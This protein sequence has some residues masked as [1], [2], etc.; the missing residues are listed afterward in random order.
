M[1]EVSFHSEIQSLRLGNGV[2]QG[3]PP[4]L[5]PVRFGDEQTVQVDVVGRL[6]GGEL[7]GAGGVADQFASVVDH[8]APGPR[9]CREQHGFQAGGEIGGDGFGTLEG[10]VGGAQ[11][12]HRRQV[13]RGGRTDHAARPCGVPQ[14]AQEMPERGAVRSSTGRCPTPVAE[15]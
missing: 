10:G 6:P 12:G 8:E 7:Q 11:A 5:S 14:H 4:P 2:E 13:C 9:T 1:A 3:V 15:S